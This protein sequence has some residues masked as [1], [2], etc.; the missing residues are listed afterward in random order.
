MTGSFESATKVTAHTTSGEYATFQVGDSIE[1][2]AKVTA[3][4][5][6]NNGK[7][8]IITFGYN[9]LEWKTAHNGPFST[10]RWVPET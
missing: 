3:I 2:G 7:S 5:I 4:A 6:D 10:L 8:F 9:D 1:G